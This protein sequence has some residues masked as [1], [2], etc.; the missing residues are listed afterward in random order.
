MILLFPWNKPYPARSHMHH[1]LSISYNCLWFL[2]TK[3][4]LVWNSFKEVALTRFWPMF[5]LYTLENDRKP[6]VKVRIKRVWNGIIAQEWANHK[7]LPTLHERIVKAH[8]VGMS[9]AQLCIWMPLNT[10]A[11][12]RYQS[13]LSNLANR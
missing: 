11:A 12:L 8:R 2:P 5:P 1:M 9:S 13:I 4:V 3:R 7:V 10:I 6:L